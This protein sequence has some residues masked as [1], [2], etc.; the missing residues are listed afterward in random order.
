[1]TSLAR[2]LEQDERQ[3]A[4]ACEQWDITLSTYKTV[5]VTFRA[6][7]ILIVALGMFMPQV[8]PSPTTLLVLAAFVL[9]P[10]VVEAYLT[11]G[12]GS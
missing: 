1:M 8:Q 6:V 5:R 9:G 12:P 3:L 7:G 11:D 2:Q 4:R 10:D